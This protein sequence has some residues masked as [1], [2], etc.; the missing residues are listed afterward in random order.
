MVPVFKLSRADMIKSILE[1]ATQPDEV[2]LENW[3]LN[4]LMGLD[5][6][7]MRRQWVV[8]P[9]NRCR[10][11][12]SKRLQSEIVRAKT[13]EVELKLITMSDASESCDSTGI[14]PARPILMA[15]LVDKAP[16]IFRP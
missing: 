16:I 15:I 13:L 7:S 3:V 2:D 10:F 8:K 9:N 5:R 6:R 4:S 1:Y 14:L 11:L 12:S